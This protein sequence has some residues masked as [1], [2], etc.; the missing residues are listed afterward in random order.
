MARVPAPIRS[1]AAMILVEMAYSRLVALSRS[2]PC[3]WSGSSRT[4]ERMGSVERLATE[5]LILVSASL[6][7]VAR[8]EKATAFLA[9]S[10]LT[11]PST[12]SAMVSW[13]SSNMVL[14]SDLKMGIKRPAFTMKAGG[15]WVVR[16]EKKLA[17]LLEAWL[18]LDTVLSGIGVVDE[19]Q[20][21]NS[22]LIVALYPHLSEPVD[23]RRDDSGESMLYDEPCLDVVISMPADF[24]NRLVTLENTVDDGFLTTHTISSRKL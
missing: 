3:S 19:G 24:P 7:S 9:S 12:R 17:F 23:I 2:R 18:L 14:L 8:T 15:T 6:K 4:L 5:S 22:W 10:S 1:T 13:L 20:N 11:S 21:W 16:R